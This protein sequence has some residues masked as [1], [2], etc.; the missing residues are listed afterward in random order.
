[1]AAVDAVVPFHNEARRWASTDS[2][3][4]QH[5]QLSQEFLLALSAISNENGVATACHLI[6]QGSIR[7]IEALRL[8]HTFQSC[9]ANSSAQQDRDAAFLGVI[10]NLRAVVGQLVMM[11]HATKNLVLQQPGVNIDNYSKVQLLTLIGRFRQQLMRC[12]AKDK[13]T[14]TRLLLRFYKNQMEGIAAGLTY[15]DHTTPRVLI[16]MSAAM[17][18]IDLQELNEKVYS[19]TVVGYYRR[20]LVSRLEATFETSILD[21]E[22]D[23]NDQMSA[24]PLKFLDQVLPEN[25]HQAALGKWKTALSFHLYDLVG[26]RRSAQLFDICIE[27]PESLPAV[28]DLERAL[29]YTSL[30]SHLITVFRQALVDRL[31]HPGAATSD[32]IHQYV[33]SIKVLNDIDS[34]G[35][36]LNI[37][38]EPI[39]DYLR[40][41]K[42]T[43]RCI[44][45]MLTDGEDEQSLLDE[46]GNM[47]G[48][49]DAVD[50]DG[51]D[52]DEQAIEE[53]ERWQPNTLE[54]ARMTDEQKTGDVINMLVGIYG[55]KEL[56]LNEYRSM[57]AD[58]LLA[59]SDY[60]CDRELRTL[61]LLKVR[62]GETSL[63]NA[64]VMLK[65]L[66]DSKRI[67]SNVK[68]VPDTATP[69]KKRK[70]L[71]GI[72]NLTATIISQLF[73]P[74][75]PQEENFNLPS[76]IKS[77]LQTYGYKYHSLKAPRVLQWKSS[78]GSV[79]LEVRIGDDVL[80]F[81]ASPFQA[82]AL[83]KFQEQPEW[84]SAELASAL[85][86]SND[87]LRKKI[88]FWLN[89]G[90]VSEVKKASGSVFV[91]NKKLQKN[92]TNADMDTGMDIDA[93]A[94]IAGE[95]MSKYEPFV[96]GMLTNFDTLPLDRIHNMLKMFAADPPYEKSLEELG[97][98]LGKLVVEEKLVIEEGTYKRKL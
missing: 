89:Q 38:A 5:Q 19:A 95:D 31:L 64:E 52:A 41:R 46:L 23:S 49:T 58:R 51:L 92:T 71:V 88:M 76:D 75:L 16:Q 1:M 66:A 33:A 62:F 60:D 78:V 24:I 17:N 30:H 43:T 42:D 97:T 96:M 20:H 13:P 29:M 93:G 40:G 25:D 68:S 12:L 56:F 83:L 27:Y 50:F 21:E 79:T 9:L 34:S 14:L 77:K 91:R 85:G 81:T 70:Q 54:T 61:E 67:N 90:V 7:C 94:G 69:L 48:Q 84:Q 32:I 74:Q 3:V 57:L 45:T 53:A 35:A 63:H 37:V 8:P 4:G 18:D 10:V 47:Q 80:E 36:I 82:T 2:D 11:F 55:T 65:D 98:F 28:R 87:Y 73:W 6:L 39:R 59:R 15:I 86:V 22:A 72:D 26:R 44:V